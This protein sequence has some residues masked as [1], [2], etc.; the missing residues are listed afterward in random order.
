M[1]SRLVVSVSKAKSSALSSFF[2]Q[3]ASC[4]SVVMV[5]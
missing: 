3:S 2:S 5:S 1:Y 4:D